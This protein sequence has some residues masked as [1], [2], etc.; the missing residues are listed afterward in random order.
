MGEGIN[1]TEEVR[2]TEE[3]T[4]ADMPNV[5]ELMKLLQAQGM[6]ASYQALSVFAAYADGMEEAL[7]DVTAELHE[8]KKQLSDMQK[9][10]APK[11]KQDILKN[12]C[13]QA[14]K[15]FKDIQDKFKAIKSMVNEK[16]GQLLQAFKEHGTVA[17]NNVCK[18]L[19]IK[20]VLETMRDTYQNHADKMDKSVAKIENIEAELH[21]AGH[22]IKNLG[23]AIAGKEAAED[24]AGESR[25]FKALKQPYINAGNR[26]RKMAAG[27]QK[28]VNAF[29]GLEKKAHEAGER[30][31]NRASLKEKLKTMQQKQKQNSQ[32]MGAEARKK[33]M[34]L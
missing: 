14:E 11:E 29:E 2:K 23:R 21:A 17:L 32:G 7:R 15:G 22:H 10:G 4:H 25:F 13:G 28:A 30:K 8:V 5:D 12:I 24:K 1:G 9:N 34:A 3:N 16:A 27:T 33:E 26:Y 6:A 31:E 18:A 20:E 19:G